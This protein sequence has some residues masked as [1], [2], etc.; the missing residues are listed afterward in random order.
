MSP[1]GAQLFDSFVF[2]QLSEGELCNPMSVNHHTDN[3]V[4]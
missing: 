4:L 3:V 1:S 2:A